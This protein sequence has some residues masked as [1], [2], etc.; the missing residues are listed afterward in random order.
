M[1]DNIEL[2]IL[3]N[4]KLEKS[5]F[6]LNKYFSL[7]QDGDKTILSRTKEEPTTYENHPTVFLI[8]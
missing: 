8:V 6:I 2:V 5:M 3:E 7:F 4:V 1:E